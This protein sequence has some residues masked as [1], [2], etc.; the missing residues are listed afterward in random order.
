MANFCI[1]TGSVVDGSL[2]PISGAVIYASP[3]VESNVIFNTS[4]GYYKGLAAFPIR[5]ISLADGSFS[6][7]LAKNALFRISIRYIG[8]D[9]VVLIPTTDTAVLWSLVGS[10]E[11]VVTTS[12]GT[13]STGIPGDD[14]PW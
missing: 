14:A 6:I 4:S 13:T 3:I 10:K 2:T 1:I 9:E 11:T 7:N 5:A 8:M 12:T